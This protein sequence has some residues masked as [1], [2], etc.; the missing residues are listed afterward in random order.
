MDQR[1]IRH[2]WYEEFD[3]E[4]MTLT[5]P[6]TK[7]DGDEELITIQAVYVVCSTCKGKGKHVNPSVDRHGITP[8]EFAEDPD[9]AEDYMKGAYDVPCVRCNGK[10]VVPEPDHDTLTPSISAQVDLTIMR[11]YQDQQEQW[12]ERERG[13]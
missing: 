1:E 13:Y 5:V 4:A 12:H 3:E 8:E 2:H 10:R 9:F 7:S 6:V 11:Y